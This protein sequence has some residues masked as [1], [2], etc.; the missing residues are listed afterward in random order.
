M[1][2]PFPVVFGLAMGKSLT[3]NTNILEFI[4]STINVGTKDKNL[5]FNVS[6]KAI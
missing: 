1:G 3:C 4:S 6:F 2:M 5:N